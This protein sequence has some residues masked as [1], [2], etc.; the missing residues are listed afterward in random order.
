[1]IIMIGL[2]RA[3]Q[4]DL[5]IILLSGIAGPLGLDETSTGADVVISKGANEIPY[6]QR[7]V[8]RLLARKVVRRPPGSQENSVPKAKTKAQSV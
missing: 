3:L 4:P 8:T 7:A 1:M 2:V 6:L 5:S